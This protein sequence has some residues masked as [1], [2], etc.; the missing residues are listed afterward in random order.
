[1]RKTHR[2][3]KIGTPVLIRLQESELYDLDL[4]RAAQKGIPTRAEAG[5]RLI[6]LGRQYSDLL[7]SKLSHNSTD[8]SEP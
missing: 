6:K 3:P 1:M 4:W 7:A 8:L 2:S 5:R